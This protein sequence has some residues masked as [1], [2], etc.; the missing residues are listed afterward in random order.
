MDVSKINKTLPS[1]ISD[2]ITSSAGRA[3]APHSIV[4]VE[5]SPLGKASGPTRA[6]TPPLTYK[7]PLKE[8]PEESPFRTV[9]VIDVLGR[10]RDPQLE[11]PE[12]LWFQIADT[13]L[14]NENLDADIR[15]DAQ[16]KSVLADKNPKNLQQ[17]LI[18]NR[19]ETLKNLQEH[20]RF[21]FFSAVKT[22]R[23]EI[24]LQPGSSQYEDFQEKA[25]QVYFDQLDPLFERE[26]PSKTSTSHFIQSL[27]YET[28]QALFALRAAFAFPSQV[29]QIHKMNNGEK[30]E[31]VILE[32][33]PPLENMAL[34]GGGVRGMVYPYVLKSMQQAGVLASLK[35]VAG[36]SAGAITIAAL[37]CGLSTEEIEHLSNFPILE[38]LRPSEESVN[39]QFSNFGF[40]EG[41]R[42]PTLIEKEGL[43]TICHFIETKKKELSTG[44][45]LT[46]KEAGDLKTLLKME[47]ELNEK[48]IITFAH[49]AVLHQINPS[50]FKNLIITGYN[51]TTKSIEYYNAETTPDMSVAQAVR[52][53]MSLPII[54]K[55]PLNEKGEAMY[56]GALFGSKT[57]VEVFSE[58]APEKTLMLEFDNNGK[59]NKIAHAP[60]KIAPSISKRIGSALASLFI[61]VS[62]NEVAHQA[63]IKL[64]EKGP[65]ALDVWHGQLGGES[66]F[67]KPEKIQQAQLQAQTRTWEWLVLRQHQAIHTV[68]ED[69]HQ[70][71]SFQQEEELKN[72][73]A[74][75]AQQN[76]DSQEQA[77]EK[78]EIVAAAQAILKERAL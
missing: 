35:S 49:L 8:E 29:P 3:F 36:S 28:L 70:Y 22:M 58:E 66:F 26:S 5:S 30:E 46:P 69:L 72:I 39:Q 19:K 62:T 4:Q 42:L 57:P 68:T 74:A 1:S 16:G 9:E 47:E 20:F 33:A 10:E 13:A 50:Q 17:S 75:Y 48:P 7:K 31:W 34:A 52:I 12:F 55:P 27:H 63:R 37:A 23:E 53:S 59:F 18:P 41:T 24:A 78:R 71:F 65:G 21:Y 44:N 60:E 51:S 45:K 64:H 76:S 40:F 77:H 11:S 32:P 56:D 25:E 54:F 67:A 73:I 15:I 61:G 2:E 43:K 6:A 38:A 14:Q